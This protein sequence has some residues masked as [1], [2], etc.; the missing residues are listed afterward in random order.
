MVYK[1]TKSITLHGL[2]RVDRLASGPV[3][4]RRQGDSFIGRKL[5]NGLFFHHRERMKRMKSKKSVK[6]CARVRMYGETY[7]EKL[8]APLR[9]D[10]PKPLPG[11]GIKL[12]I[13]DCLGL[14]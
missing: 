8:L 9:V 2:V 13:F 11:C 14:D 10:R 7:E 12:F 5:I 3:S 6:W 4:K 1:T